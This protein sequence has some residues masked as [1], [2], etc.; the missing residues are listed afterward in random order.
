MALAEN[1]TLSKPDVLK[2]ET[3]R[4][5]SD[6]KSNEFISGFTHQW[7]DMKRVDTS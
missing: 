3:Q 1:G 7:L 2:T 4:L 5:L 6:P